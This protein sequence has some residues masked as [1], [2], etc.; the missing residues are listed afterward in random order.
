MSLYD[1]PTDWQD[2]T[3]WPLEGAT[4]ASGL[5]LALPLAVAAFSMVVGLLVGGAGGWMAGR[6]TSDEPVLVAA[7]DPNDIRFGDVCAP[8]TAEAQ[9]RIE[10]LNVRIGGLEGEIG[11]RER[12]VLEL[13]AEMERRAARGRA[14]VAELTQARE[15]LAS[16]R[17]E[18]D[19]LVAAKAQLVEELGRANRRIALTERALEEQVELTDRVRD[20][21]LASD[22]ARFVHEAQLDICERGT[23]KKLGRCREIVTSLLERSAVRERFEHCVR[24]GQATPRVS[25]LA[26]GETLPEF[27]LHLDQDEKV[28]RDW[29][30]HLCDPTLPEN[31]ALLAS[32]SR[33]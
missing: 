17:Q 9:T 21:A 8:V 26:R 28:V 6:A 31:D 15:A 14:L 32:A 27:S 22:F 13:E 33:F 29:Y 3:E 7:I 24:S 25:E 2:E 11:D 23:R 12:K 18:R 10:E 20:R 30:L 1:E 16:A 5:M 4:I 19:M